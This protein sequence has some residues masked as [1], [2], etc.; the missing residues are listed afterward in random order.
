MCGIVGVRAAISDGDRVASYLGAMNQRQ[1]HRGPDDSGSY[2]DRECRLGLAMRRLAILDLD[3]GAQPMRS[4]DGRHVLVFNGEIFNSPELR[5]E[6]EARG[7]RFRTAHS[8]TEVLL[9]LLVRESEGALTKLNGMFAFAF[10]DRFERTLLLARDRLGIKP[11]YYT[12]IGTRFAFASEMKS[13]LALPFINREIDR[14]SLFHYLSLMYVPGERSIL[15]DVHRLPPGHSLR[16][17]LD[18]GVS[19]IKRW[20]GLHYDPD[21]ATPAAMWPERI[22]ATLDEAVDRWCLSDVPIAASLSGGLDSSGIVGLASRRGRDVRTVSVGFAGEGEAAW[23]ELPLAAR[24]AEM[25]KTDHTAITI[26]PDELLGALPRM[27]WHLDE[28]YG[29][30]L[31]SWTVFREM[32][33]FVKVGLTGV[34][35]DELFGNYGKWRALEGGAARRWVD[36]A[37]TYE[38]FR[39]TYF[40]RWHYFTDL[41]KRAVLDGEAAELEDTAAFLWRRYSEPGAAAVRD[42]T[43]RTEIGTQLADE[44]LHMVDRFSMAHS[45]EA[46]TPFLDNAMVDLVRTI[47]ASIRTRRGDLKGLLRHALA[48]VLPEALLTAPKHGF[49]LP[50]KLW[51]RGPLRPL[52]ERLLAPDRLRRQ[53]LFRPDTYYRHVRPHLEGRE[54]LTTRAWGLV[55]FQLWHSLTVERAQ[56]EVPPDS[57]GELTEGA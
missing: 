36:A 27:V 52:A 32:S 54:D 24:V 55:M 46:R 4:D 10:Y 18:D 42:R 20:W 25:W 8:D 57:L 1:Y 37:P 29:G 19:E 17:R 45:L 41:D 56:T 40:D 49:V 11:L 12:Q 7:E 23:N 35:G 2:L 30:G 44:F 6:L 39:R 21:H 26:A 48:P 38:R 51:L 50:L 15:R 31:P 22:R 43:A 28:P 16:L 53:G 3:G 9:R 5:R 34:G 47:P 14:Q 33:R 13:L